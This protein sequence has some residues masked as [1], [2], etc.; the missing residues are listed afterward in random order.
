MLYFVL[1]GFMVKKALIITIIA[2]V[3]LVI[4]CV[5]ISIVN[6]KPVSFQSSVAYDSSFNMITAPSYERAS[7]TDLGL[8]SI[9]TLIKYE[10]TVMTTLIILVILFTIVF[11]GTQRSR[12]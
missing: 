3:I 10:K 11:M 4:V 12:G 8:F 5:I 6:L 7:G 1:G 2:V 9:L